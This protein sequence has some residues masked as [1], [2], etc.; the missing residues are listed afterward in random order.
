VWAA[1]LAAAQALG[2]PANAVTVGGGAAGSVLVAVFGSPA[3][4]T[5]AMPGMANV[6]TAALSPATTLAGAAVAVGPA[7]AACGDGSTTSCSVPSALLTPA[8]AA[9]QALTAGAIAGIAVAAV[10]LVAVLLAGVCV[11]LQHM[12]RRSRAR[13]LYT[14]DGPPPASP[15]SPGTAFHVEPPAALRQAMSEAAITAAAAQATDAVAPARSIARS[16]PRGSA[17]TRPKR[18]QPARGAHA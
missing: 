5:A 16:G 2:V 6:T 9:P 17:P 12:G 8:E 10:A 18:A 13:D 3:A 15:R 14:A 11:S 1:R 7:T 4:A